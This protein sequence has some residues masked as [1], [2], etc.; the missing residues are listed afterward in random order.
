MTAK[1][2]RYYHGLL[3]GNLSQVVHLANEV[4][5][6]NRMAQPRSIGKELTRGDVLHPCPL[7]EIFDGEF[8]PCSIPVKL[9]NFDGL[10][11]KI[12]HKPEVSPVGKE[13]CLDTNKSGAAYDESSLLIDSLCHL[14]LTTLGIVN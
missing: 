3:R 14:G 9:I 11:V 7:L 1:G 10:P 4:M 6:D 12:G 13:F 2:T 8:N 5:R